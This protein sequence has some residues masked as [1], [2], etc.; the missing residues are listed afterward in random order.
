MHSSPGGL[1]W[2]EASTE[3]WGG[4]G[5]VQ[6]E[7]TRSPRLRDREPLLA[8]TTMCAP[9]LSRVLLLNLVARC[10]SGVN[11]NTLRF[12]APQL[13]NSGISIPRSPLVVPRFAPNKVLTC[14]VLC[15]N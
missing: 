13:P 10:H 1:E 14:F 6:A 7:F 12:E 4:G 8:D 15:S 9:A 2:D 3:Q 11:A 5:E